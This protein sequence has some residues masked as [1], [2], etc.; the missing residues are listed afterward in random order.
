MATLSAAT[1]AIAY[2]CIKI[3]GALLVGAVS[4]WAAIWHVDRKRQSMK[5]RRHEYGAGADPIKSLPLRPAPCFAGKK[6]ER[7]AHY[8]EVAHRIKTGNGGKFSGRGFFGFMVRFLSYSDASHWWVPLVDD[9]GIWI[10]DSCE[11]KGVTKRSLFE[12]VKKYPGQYYVADIAPEFEANYDRKAVAAGM[13]AT[14]G[15]RYGYL[16]IVFQALIHT[17]VLRELAYLLSI[18]RLFSKLLPFCS[19]YGLIHI[20]SGGIDCVKG[21]D[22]QLVVP[23]DMSQSPVFGEWVALVP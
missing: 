14:I 16:G 3:I 23:Q 1:L 22:P 21:R 8:H 7:V 11:G 13:L 4:L 12:D 15:R 9:E 6:Q 19:G 2:W 18:D 10:V 20:R 5:P 17:P